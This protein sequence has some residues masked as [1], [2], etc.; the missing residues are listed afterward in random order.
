MTMIDRWGAPASKPTPPESSQK[1]EP[2]PKPEPESEKAGIDLAAIETAVS[3]TVNRVIDERLDL[4]GE[5][6]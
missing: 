1:S 4:V 2:E 6:D 3:R 5:D